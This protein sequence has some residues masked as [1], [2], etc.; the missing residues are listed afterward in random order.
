VHNAKNIEVRHIPPDAS[1]PGICWLDCFHDDQMP[2]PVDSI[3]LLQSSFYCH[4]VPS[5]LP[6]VSCCVIT[7]HVMAFPRFLLLRIGPCHALPRTDFGR[8]LCYHDIHLLA[9]SYLLQSQHPCHCHIC[10]AEHGGC[11]SAPAH[12]HPA[13]HEQPDIVAA[14]PLYLSPVYCDVV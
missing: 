11:M 8:M 13:H 2:F 6:W 5:V 10:P 9:F 7:A 4:L 14:V 1:V 12:H 3:S